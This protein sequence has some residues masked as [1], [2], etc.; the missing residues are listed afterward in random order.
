M[1][2]NTSEATK[3]QINWL[4][5]KIE[6]DKVCRPRLGRPDDWDRA[7][8]EKG[9]DD[10]WVVRVQVPNVAWFAD[11]VYEPTSNWAQGGPIIEREGIAVWKPF[12]KT[13]GEWKAHYSLTQCEQT[14]PTP[15]IAAM[16]CFVA[17]KLGDEVEVPEELT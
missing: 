4:V 15:L 7:A 3:L 8:W 13:N 6:G 11:Y 5:A 16:R 2:V 12:D 9:E 10:R 17:S 1:K 14:G